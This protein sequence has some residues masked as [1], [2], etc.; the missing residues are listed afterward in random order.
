MNPIQSGLALGLVV[1]LG[2][3]GYLYSQNGAL[4]LEVDAAN[5]RVSRLQ[6]QENQQTGALEE[7][8]E[9]KARLA[10]LEQ[11]KRDL[12]Q[13]LEQAVSGNNDDAKV[14]A[15]DSSV[16]VDLLGS[17]LFTPVDAHLTSEG[18][19]LLRSIADSLRNSSGEIQIVGHTDAW[20]IA[21]YRRDVYASNWELA[22]ARAISVAKYLKEELDIDPSRLRA[23]SAAQYS[24]V[25][26]NGSKEGRAA[27]RR[28][29]I[30][31]VNL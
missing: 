8:A 9:I 4:Q 22:A 26:D 12:Q 28:I 14:T 2:G 6:Q 23:V 11:V 29:E 1:A 24:P 3:V 30:K 7:L 21:E 19:A 10:G 20:P 18:T 15:T 31:I 17:V 5:G 25:A 13:E 27:N 16:S